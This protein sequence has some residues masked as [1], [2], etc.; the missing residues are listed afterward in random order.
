MWLYDKCEEIWLTKVLPM[1]HVNAKKRRIVRAENKIK[2]QERQLKRAKWG[3]SYSVFDGEE[4]LEASLKSVRRSADYINVVYQTLSW[5]GERRND[6]LPDFLKTLQDKGLIDELIFF[7]PDANKRAYVNEKHKRNLGLKRARKE[8]CT[9]FMTMDTDEFY[10][11]EEMEAAKRE[12]LQKGITHS[13]CGFALYG[14][15]PTQRALSPGGYAVCFFSK[16]TRFTRVGRNR[17]IQARIDASRIP[18]HFPFAKYAFLGGVV[19]HHFSFV[20]KSLYDKLYNSSARDFDYMH[21]DFSNKQVEALKKKLAAQDYMTVEN[22]FGI[23]IDEG[24]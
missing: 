11:F 17:H 9:Y 4:L 13:F 22:A 23:D 10:R 19:M 6:A 20:R 24:R 15:K 3:I 2:L 14:A 16:L 8:G 5:T 21:G 7:A 12:I 18:S 1:M